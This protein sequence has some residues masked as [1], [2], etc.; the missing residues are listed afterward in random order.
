MENNQLTVIVQNSGLEPTEGQT[1]LEKFNSYEEVAR[2]WENKAKAIVVTDVSQVA[3]MKMAREGRLFLAQKRIDV[4]KARKALKEQSLRKGQAIDAI[5]K[6]LTSLIEPTEKYLKEQEDFVKIQAEKEADRLRIEAEAK[7]EV[8]RLA[9]E[10]V[11][12]EEQERIR[13]EI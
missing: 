1:I 4:E 3:E 11:E 9:K 8:E 7:A 6:F 12:R 2:D 5:A 10:K 13:L